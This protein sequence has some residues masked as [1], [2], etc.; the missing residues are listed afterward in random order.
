MASRLERLYDEDFHAW[1]REQAKALRRLAET[2]PN[3]EIDFRH[4]VEEVRDLGKSERDAVRSQL[5]RL[6]EHLLKL[7]HSPALE[8]REGWYDTIGDARRELYFKLSPSLR[9]DIDA[10]LPEL[11]ALARRRAAQA[12]TRYG[13]VDAA[14]TL[15]ETCPYSLAQLLDDAWF[16]VPGI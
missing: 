10:R 15:P 8:P 5:A 16:P 12:L 3:D 14:D 4:L 13:E 6:L 1:T 9:R 11:Y 2:R 7:E